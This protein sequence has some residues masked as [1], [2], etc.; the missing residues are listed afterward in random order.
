MDTSNLLQKAI[1]AARSGRELT[2]RDLFQDV[3]RLDPD[4]EVAWMWLSGLLDPLNDR[5][6]ACERVLDINPKNEKIRAY[7]DDL[8]AEQQAIHRDK[9]TEIDDWLQQVRWYAEDGKKEEA[10]AHLQ[11]ILREEPDHK[12]AWALFAEL[13]VSLRDKVRAYEEI[14]HIDPLDVDAKK[15]LKRYAYYQRH[16]LELAAL[17][18]EDGKPDKAMELYR[19]LAAEAGNSSSFE[20][21]YKNIV[22][23]ER[24]KVENIQYVRPSLHILRLSIGLPLL[25]LLEVFMQE[26]LSPIKH[27]APDLWI[28]IPLVMSGSFLIAVATVPSRHKIWQK[29]FGDRGGRGSTAAR[30][31]VTFAGWVLVLTPH[32]LLILDSVLRLRTFETPLIPWF[33]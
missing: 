15:K 23:L 25:Y 5:I 17:Y 32:L 6:S 10:L 4:N 7:L 28:G 2:A 3:V 11:Y 33:G 21:I 31:L 20:A 26:G 27:P 1:Q 30:S 16:P 13:S 29:W 8:R 22:R 12:N 14:V 9:S 18:E 19:V 24:A